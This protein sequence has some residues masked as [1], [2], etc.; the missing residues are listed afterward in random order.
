LQWHAWKTYYDVLVKLPGAFWAEETAR[1]WLENVAIE[2]KHLG[3]Y[4]PAHPTVNGPSYYQERRVMRERP[5]NRMENEDGVSQ[6]QRKRRESGSER[7]ERQEGR[8]RN[9]RQENRKDNERRGDRTVSGA[10]TADH[11]LRSMRDL[12][13]AAW[14]ESLT[15]LW[16]EL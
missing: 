14:R 6:V 16:Q 1:D 4:Q 3:H 12:N 13:A 10:A 8:V 2:L 5:R 9:D 15:P 7:E 11:G